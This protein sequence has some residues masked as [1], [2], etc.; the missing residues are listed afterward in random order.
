MLLAGFL[1]LLSL[2][3]NNLGMSW[4]IHSG[5]LLPAG[6]VID[7]HRMIGDNAGTGCGCGSFWRADRPHFF[8]SLLLKLQAFER[9]AFFLLWL[10]NGW[11]HNLFDLYCQVII[12]FCC[13]LFVACSFACFDG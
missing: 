6:V 4:S 10:R 12:C 1:V 7:E 5:E 8:Q 9:A 13:C 2:L 11:A 3:P